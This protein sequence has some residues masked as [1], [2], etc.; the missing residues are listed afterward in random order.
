[1]F[2]PIA[3][4]VHNRPEHTRRVLDALRSNELASE[5]DLIVFSDG[6]RTADAKV[7]VEEVRALIRRIDGFRSV[8]IRESAQN[9][10]LAKSIIDGVTEVCREH[11]RI[12][13]L[14]D[15][16]ITSPWFLRYM[17]DALV[18]YALDERVISVHGYAFPVDEQLPETF[19]L[20]GADCWGWAT[21]KRGW[22]LFEQN[23]KKL[24]E[25]LRRRK[26]TREFDLDG[27]YPYVRMLEDQIAGKK[28]SWAIRWH[29]SAYLADRLTLY[30][31]TSLVQN[32]GNDR[33][34]THSGKTAEFL[35]D[36]ARSRTS[37]VRIPLE[38]CSVARTAVV[39]C[40]NARKR[41]LI[42]RAIDRIHRLR[43]G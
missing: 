33:S 38:E 10:G 19:F 7:S 26:I 21:W 2:A 14:E 15:D 13:V 37:V 20:R 32:I 43:I 18:E 40:L 8:T 17:N 3:L 1:M 36:L 42:S 9:K 12:I 41:G 30:P 31:G 22:D 11:G 34:G 28:D 25:E 27:A 23:G 35:V 5:S 39:R 29:A 4:F 24:L 16:L 6:P